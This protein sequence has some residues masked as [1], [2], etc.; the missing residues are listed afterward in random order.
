M[1]TYDIIELTF[2]GGMRS[3]RKTFND[4]NHFKNWWALMNKKGVKIMD[5]FKVKTL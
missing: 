3:Y 5:V 4:E 1:V 2:Y